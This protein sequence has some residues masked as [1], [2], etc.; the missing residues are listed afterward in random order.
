MK[1]FNT[2]YVSIFYFSIVIIQFFFQCLIHLIIF[3]FNQTSEIRL[4]SDTDS[5]SEYDD[6]NDGIVEEIHGVD[7]S[8]T[9]LCVNND[10]ISNTPNEIFDNFEGCITETESTN[11]IYSD[12]FEN[13]IDDQV[14]RTENG[15]NDAKLL[16]DSKFNLSLTN[17][18]FE[19]PQA[20]S[21]K[22]DYHQ[23]QNVFSNPLF[24]NAIYQRKNL[25]TSM[26][27]L[28]AVCETKIDQN[29][30]E[31]CIVQ[32]VMQKFKVNNQFIL[33]KPK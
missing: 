24:H 15:H 12:A 22:L 23:S 30:H 17:I 5:W 25:S 21:S 9:L 14:Y 29:D 13:H 1:K 18:C 6:N 3:K 8:E 33:F 31:T 27:S 20:S 16:K 26:K 7:D 4:R 32:E 19:I 10:N 28:T 2:T 11:D